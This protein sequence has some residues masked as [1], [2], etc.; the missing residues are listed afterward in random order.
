MHIHVGYYSPALGT[1]Y[2]CQQ[3]ADFC[4]REVEQRY[5]SLFLLLSTTK[6]ARRYI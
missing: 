1:L 6:N 5:F 2:K 3:L 4:F